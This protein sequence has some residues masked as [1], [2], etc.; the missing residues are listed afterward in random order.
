MGELSCNL[1]GYYGRKGVLTSKDNVEG[2][3]DRNT[4]S[5]VGSETLREDDKK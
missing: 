2:S 3:K 1:N 5:N 4:N